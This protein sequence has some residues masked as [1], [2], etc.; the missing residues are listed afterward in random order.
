MPAMTHAAAVAPS[1]RIMAVDEAMTAGIALTAFSA[2]I[3]VIVLLAILV[4][5][6]SIG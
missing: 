5:P 3:L 2:L 1:R 4:V 6:A